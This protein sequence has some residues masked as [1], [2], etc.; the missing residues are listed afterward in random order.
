MLRPA[1]YLFAMFLVTVPAIADDSPKTARATAQ[2]IDKVAYERAV[3]RGIE[4]LMTKG[5]AADGSFS[6]FAG[7][8]PT[9]LITASLLEHGQSPQDPKIA[10]SLSYIA[11]HIQKDGGIYQTGTYYR[12]Y[13]TCLA[14][15]C[16]SKANKDGRYDK[17]IQ[18]ADA[19]L[20]GIQWGEGKDKSDPV[21]GGG[22]YGR[23]K[24]PDLSN[25]GFLIEA[26]KSAGNEADSEAIQRALMFVSRCQNLESAHNQTPFSAKVN[27]GGFYYTPAAGGSSQ[28]GKTPD[29]GLRSYGAMTYTGLK[30]LLYAG[31]GPKDERVKAAISW[32][33]KHY[34]LSANPG[35]GNA[36]LYYYYHVFAKAL[37][38]LGQDSIESDDGVKHN[39]RAELVAELV[40]RQQSD[41]SWVNE[42][43]RWLEGDPNLA[44]GYSLL[45][46]SYC[47]P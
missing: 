5:Q 2:K 4:Y 32:I 41:G 15:M 17:A 28:A 38:T 34:D 27:D 31:V 39:W 29:G 14:V 16:L 25:T 8:G 35:M 37:N 42:N 19:F 40:K 44:T 10:K 18:G 12:N 23:N 7:M 36:G 11:S 47:R 3:A 9:A 26:L 21:Y 13:E 6:S 43:E 20:K 24:R 46:L 45:A 1:L 30:S 22:G 33:T